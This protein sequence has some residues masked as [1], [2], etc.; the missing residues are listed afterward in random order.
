MSTRD[1]A[2]GLVIGFILGASAGLALALLLT[3]KSG[4]QTR[5]LVKDSVTEIPDMIKEQTADRKKVYKKT[6]EARKDQPLISQRY[7]E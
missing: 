6:W 2:T 3:P 4:K 1:S 7:F 5:E